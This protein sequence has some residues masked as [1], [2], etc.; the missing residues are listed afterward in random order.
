[1]GTA[2]EGWGKA[3]RSKGR[4]SLRLLHADYGVPREIIGPYLESLGWHYTSTKERP[5]GRGMHLRADELP[6]GRLIVLPRHVCAVIDGVIHDTSDWGAEG[7]RRIL[8]Y[9][10]SPG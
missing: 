5:R 8:G 1:V 3:A 6:A 9:W 4:V 10:S 7:R 2:K